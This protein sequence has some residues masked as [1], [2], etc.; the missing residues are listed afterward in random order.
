MN[1]PISLLTVDQHP[2][3]VSSKLAASWLGIAQPNENQLFT[4]LVA[5]AN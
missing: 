3:P 4:S 5:V 1:Y 2:G